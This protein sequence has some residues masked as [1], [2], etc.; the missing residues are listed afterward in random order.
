M[1]HH[2]YRTVGTANHLYHGPQGH[3]HYE[4][5]KL[6]GPDGFPMDFMMDLARGNRPVI[7]VSTVGPLLKGPEAF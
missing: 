2:Y 1:A 7:Q 5:S 3:L 6:N 4:T